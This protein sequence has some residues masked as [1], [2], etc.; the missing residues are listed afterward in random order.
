MRG[1][2]SKGWVVRVGVLLLSGAALTAAACGSGTSSSDKTA[3]AA[4]GAAPAS[5]AAAA[6]PTAQAAAP[7]AAAASATSATGATVKLAAAPAG[8]SLKDETGAAVTQYLTDGSG[9][10]LYTYK[11]DV[12]NSGKS[13]VPANI[14]PNWPPLTIASGAPTAGAGVTGTLGT[15]TGPDGSTW[16]TYNGKPLYHFKG[17][18]APGDTKGEGLLNVWYVAGP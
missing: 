14:L 6:T 17:D 8:A 1:S 15:M 16:V 18:A 12:A 10:T 13:A 3:T 2:A 11:N 9:M 7:T 4:A 5:T